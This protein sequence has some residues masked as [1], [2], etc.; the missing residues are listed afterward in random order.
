MIDFSGLLQ[1]RIPD[2]WCLSIDFAGGAIVQEDSSCNSRQ[3][4]LTAPAAAQ[5][6]ARQSRVLHTLAHWKHGEENTENFQ[7]HYIPKYLTHTGKPKTA[8]LALI[9]ST[10]NILCW[11][12]HLPSPPPLQ[13]TNSS[14]PAPALRQSSTWRVMMG[15]A[16]RTLVKTP[17]STSYS[18]N[19]DVID[20]MWFI[21]TTLHFHQEL[22]HFRFL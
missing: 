9:F 3:L 21:R 17:P 19:H 15:V 20:I 14:D 22:Q 18:H 16:E 8:V 11:R 10:R 5:H 6:Q 1:I 4:T 12:H 13:P 2:L 7:T